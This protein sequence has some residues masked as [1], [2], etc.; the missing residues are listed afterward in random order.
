[1]KTFNF[2]SFKINQMNKNRILIL[3][4]L[5]FFN[6]LISNSQSLQDGI[7]QLENENY[8][9]ALNTFTKL[10]VSDPKTRSMLIT[11]GRCIMRWKTM[12]PQKQ[13]TKLV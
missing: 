12:K 2:A 13:L 4:I 3:S 6:A 7:K 11:L 1:M 8:S 9:A 5:L 10:N